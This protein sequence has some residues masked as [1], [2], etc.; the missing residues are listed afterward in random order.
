MKT[1]MRV[2]GLLF[3]AAL[4]LA[5]LAQAQGGKTYAITGA[6]IFTLAGP[7]IA[8]GTVVIRDGKIAGVGAKVSIPSGAQVIRAN[9]LE[10]YPG[11]FDAVTQL[12]LV[13]VGQGAPG[14]VDLNELGD[15][16]PQVV[17][18]TAVHPASEHLPVVRANGI[19]HA[20]AAPGG[21]V[22]SGQ[23][24]AIHLAGWVIDEL[25]IRK[26]AAMVLNW[27]SLASGPSFDFATFQ[28]RR[29]PFT[30][31]K[32]EY[33]RR[34]TELTDWL[35]RARHYAQAM[36]E[37]ARDNFTRDLKLEAMVPVVKGEMPVLLMTNGDRDI[38]NAV[39]FA[40]KQ[41]LK[42]I[43][44]GGRDAWKVKDLLKQ[45][46]IPVILRKTQSLPAGE[47]EPYDKPYSAPGEL[48][49]AGVKIAFATFDTEFAR[50]LPYEA[51]H[52][53]GY[54][55]P[56]DEALKAV[57]LYPAQMLGLDK[58][59]GTIESGK[60]ANLIVTNGDPLEIRTEVRF[61]FIRGQLTSNDNKHKQ[62]YEKYR[63]RP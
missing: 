19:T 54:G 5:P 56:H 26:N 57:T 16:N 11:M 52:A 15:Y 27:P 18:A 9:G 55:L 44:A 32:Q 2:C 61:L 20:L 47:D 21:G 50:T 63:A 60:I 43:I 14:T 25:A 40:E 59:L 8:N 39:E 7:P 37:G 62:L 22:V 36:E 17:A 35:E 29:R 10:V 31:V 24:S 38:K 6:K 23:A 48:A 42:I 13:E 45:K 1:M 53:V 34:V 51:G 58:E 12:G 28:V 4:L 49:A 3:V 46:D 33:E 30:E 41:K